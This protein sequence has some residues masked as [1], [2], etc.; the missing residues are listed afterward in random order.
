[1]SVA[2]LAASMRSSTSPN[3]PTIRCAS[4]TRRRPTRSTI[5]GSVALAKA[6]KEAGVSP[7]RLCLIM[8]H[9][10]RAGDEAQDGDL[11]PNSAD[12]LRRLQD[13]GR[14]RREARWPRPF[15]P[16]VPAQRDGVRRLAAYAFRHRPQQPRRPRV[17]DQAHPHDQRRHAVAARWCTCED[18]SDAVAAV[19]AGAGG[20]VAGEIFNVGGNGQ[21]YRIREIVETVGG[22]LPRLLDR[23]RGQPR[24]QPQLPR[25][26]REDR[27]S[28]CRASAAVGTCGAARQELRGVF[29]RIAMDEQ[30]F[31]APPFTRLRQLKQLSRHRPDR[32]RALLARDMIFS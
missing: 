29:E 14:A 28:G 26:V 24:R 5:C 25:L 32:R 12:R 27:R 6:A 19:L 13:A 16:D 21:N 11:R 10:R 31:T 1:M 22:S 8:Q 3:C 15:A 30:T 2:D 17:D 4:T 9:L 7:L 18:I 23:D 20:A